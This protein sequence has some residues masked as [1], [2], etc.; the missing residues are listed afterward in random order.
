MF[1]FEGGCKAIGASVATY[2]KSHRFVD[3]YILVTKYKNGQRRSSARSTWIVYSISGVK[4][5]VLPFYV[6]P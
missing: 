2:L 5:K 4:S 1:L 6:E 3:G